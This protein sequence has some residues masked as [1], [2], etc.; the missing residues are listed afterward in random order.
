VNAEQSARRAREP[1]KSAAYSKAAYDKNPEKFRE[2]RRAWSQA[3]TD[4]TTAYAVEYAKRPNVR[5]RIRTRAKE[6]FST[7]ATFS[8]NHRMRTRLRESLAFIGGKNG[9]RWESLVGY[10]SSDLHEH[11][12]AQFLKGMSWE[13]MSLWEIDHIVALASFDIQVLG[14][15]EFNAAWALSNLRPLWREANRSKSDKR[16]FLL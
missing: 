15:A 10:S 1:E 2:R 14:D 7:D 6:R 12:Q 13:N 11:L 9:R 16:L 3:N 8:I 4:K 5:D